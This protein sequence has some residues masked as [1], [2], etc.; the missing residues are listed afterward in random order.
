M[1]L[2]I[3]IGNSA[4][5]IA[6]FDPKGQM[7]VRYTYEQ[8]GSEQVAELLRENTIERAILASTRNPDAA[9]EQFL[10]QKI[11]RVVVFDPASTPTP[12]K[13]GYQTPETLGADRLAAA[14][15]AWEQFPNQDIWVVD[16]GTA[17]TIDFVS[18]K[19]VYEGGNISAGLYLRLSALHEKT[20][21]LPLCS[22]DRATGALIGVDTQSAIVQGALWGVVHEIE[23]YA[24]RKPD[25]KLFFTGGDVVYFEKQI[26]NPIFADSDAVLKGLYAVLNFD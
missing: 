7:V 10:R 17:I 12:L 26:K 23:G 5:K 19:G 25:A 18:K 14:V 16:C 6:L 24:A 20:A 13:M 15:A 8:F 3:D 1:D 11:K 21:R 9:L 2:V 22:I 4:A